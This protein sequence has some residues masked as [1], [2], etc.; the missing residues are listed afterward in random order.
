[1]SSGAGALTALAPPCTPDVSARL[2][3]GARLAAA[4]SGKLSAVDGLVGGMAEDHSPGGSI[5]PLFAPALLDQFIRLAVGD[6]LF[7]ARPAAEFPP[8]LVAAVP[9]L[10]R[11]ASAGGGRWGLADLLAATTVVTAT[12]LP[13]GGISSFQTSLR[14]E[15]WVGGGRRNGKGVGK[16]AS[17]GGALVGGPPW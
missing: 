5:G 10:G 2:P 6:R 17:G 13:R 14:H 11:A 3:T 12:S 7:Y 16:G 8:A 1:M 4:C 15:S 9:E